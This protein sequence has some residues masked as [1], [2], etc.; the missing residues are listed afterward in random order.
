MCEQK[1]N[2][3]VTIFKNNNPLVESCQ[4]IIVAVQKEGIKVK[5]KRRIENSFL[6]ERAESGEQ[7]RL[8]KFLVL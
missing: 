8:I 7:T 3:L 4:T 2:F 5:I 1:L 6:I